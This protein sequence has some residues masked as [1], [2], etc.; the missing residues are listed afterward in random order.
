MRKYLEL[1]GFL[2]PWVLS[3][4]LAGML[5]VK[6]EVIFTIRST[7]EKYLAEA[8]MRSAVY[9]LAITGLTETKWQ[10]ESALRKAVKQY[11]D[12]DKEVLR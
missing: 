9:D 8:S 1:F 3:A 2:L 7:Y 10:K 12:K 5:L 11:N 4:F 6:Q